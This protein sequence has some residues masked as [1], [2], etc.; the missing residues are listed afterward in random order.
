[1]R[2]QLRLE[3]EKLPVSEGVLL[4]RRGVRRSQQAIIKKKLTE[5]FYLIFKPNFKSM[6]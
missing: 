2:L 3:F 6:E 5:Y 4:V 1:M